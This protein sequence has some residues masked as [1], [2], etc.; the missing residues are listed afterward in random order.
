MSNT[1]HRWEDPPGFSL[2]DIISRGNSGCI[3]RKPSRTSV[4]KY[5]CPWQ[6]EAIQ[7]EDPVYQR[8]GHD[9]DFM[10]RYRGKYEKGIELEYVSG[11]CLRTVVQELGD[12]DPNRKF[13]WACQHVEAI[14]YIH[15]M[16][17]CYWHLSMQ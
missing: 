11:G 13:R 10:V 14:R 9:C 12:C 2:Q 3:L 1:D 15:S 17:I 6:K 16:N 4:I 5:P 8:L 7:Q